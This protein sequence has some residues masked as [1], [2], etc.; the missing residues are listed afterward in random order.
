MTEVEIEGADRADPT[1]AI[2][3]LGV[4][5]VVVSIAGIVALAV[6]VGPEAIVAVFAGVGG[7]VKVV[8]SRLA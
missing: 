3:V 4:V 5:S 8:S 7:L 6:G 2:K 1:T